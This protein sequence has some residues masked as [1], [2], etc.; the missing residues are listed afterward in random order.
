M[1]NK[2]C[3]KYEIAEVRQNLHWFLFPSARLKHLLM[4]F[5]LL[6]D[7]KQTNKQIKKDQYYHIEV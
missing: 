3:I 5:S 7:V 1:V 6:P 4:D 2:C